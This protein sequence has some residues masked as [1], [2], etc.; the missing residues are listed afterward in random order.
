MNINYYTTPLILRKDRPALEEKPIRKPP[1][2][3]VFWISWTVFKLFVRHAQSKFSKR[4]TPQA[5]AIKVRQF[6]EE[7]GG[8][9]IKV[10]QVLAMR[11][12]LFP[13]EF[14]NE[15]SRLQDRS[16]TFS[17]QR[18]RE[19]IEENIGARITDV[20]EYF[21]EAPFAAASLSQ[22]HKARL[23]KT[24]EWVVIKV[25]RPYAMQYFL[26]DVRWLGWFFKLLKVMGIMK[27]FR[28]DRML[29]EVH[30]MMEEELDY[31]REASNMRRLRKILDQ[32]RII[33][34][35]VHLDYSTDRVLVMDYL[36]GVFMSDYINVLRRDPAKASAW[37]AENNIEPKRVARRL[38]QS[39]LRQLYEDLFFHADLHPGN[40]V[41][42]KDN[43]LAF[44]D[45]GNCGK[46]DQKLA[47]QYQQYFRALSENALD[48]AADLLLLT[49][50]KL[51]P[52]DVDEFKKRLVK[53]LEKQVSRSYV[54]NL[55]Y[56][57]KSIGSNSAELN[58]LMAEY[59]IEVNWDML[60]MA[61]AFES[62]DQNISVLNPHFNFTTEMQ[63]YQQKAAQRKKL[64]QFRQLPNIIEQIAD[65]SQIILPSLLQRSLTVS[66]SVGKGI[67]IA[68]AIFGLIKKVLVLA[69]IAAIWTYLYQYH[70][71]VVA[72]FHDDQKD[73]LTKVGATKLEQETP[74]L[75]PAAWFFWAF[76]ILLVLVQL[77]K[78]TRNLLKPED[79]VVRQNK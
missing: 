29:Q 45:F 76:V 3:R 67:Q 73:F 47:A 34:P 55:P 70:H 68:A 5:R 27:H 58:R 19:I 65:F 75:D 16:I 4:V 78:F 43:R 59:E 21:E 39:I 41:L 61:R 46:V 31:R 7:L 32:H 62:V 26:Y 71:R 54:R 11:T 24:G 17:S 13:L 12:D 22:V 50:G 64:G 35:R 49:L 15:L 9:W 60:K 37:L 36:D 69:F 33:I 63:R 44:I 2:S 57:E 51:P 6:L 74:K 40:I 38:F 77:R 56:R 1:F 28:L 66:G 20:F 52:M 18:S 42:L 30:E 25:Q 72:M 79:H 10:G 53:I 23:Q 14:C 8:M 48:K